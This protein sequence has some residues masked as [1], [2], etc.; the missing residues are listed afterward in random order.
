[1]CL[2]VKCDT[3]VNFMCLIDR[4]VEIYVYEKAFVLDKLAKNIIIT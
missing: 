2:E 3:E 4:P 1:M